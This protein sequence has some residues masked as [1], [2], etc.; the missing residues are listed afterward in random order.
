MGIFI[1][2]KKINRKTK[3]IVLLL[4]ALFISVITVNVIIDRIIRHNAPKDS[5]DDCGFIFEEPESNNYHFGKCIDC[6]IILISLDGFRPDHL[7][8][9]GYFRDTSPNIDKIAEKGVMFSNTYS[10]SYWTLPSDTTMF[11][12]LYPS[13][14]QRISDLMYKREPLPLTR[15][16]KDND[17]LTIGF[18]SA[19]FLGK[20]SFGAGFDSYM[21]DYEV[22]NE[23][24]RLVVP[25]SDKYRYIYDAIVSN[26]DRKFFMFIHSNDAWTQQAYSTEKFDKENKDSIVHNPFIWPDPEDRIAL[27]HYIAH[28]D[29]G[30]FLADKI[31]GDLN[32]LLKEQGIDNKTMLVL[33]SDHGHE[34]YEHGPKSFGHDAMSLDEE[35]IRVIFIIYNPNS[36][37][38]GIVID[39]PVG[40]IDLLP[41]ILEV[42]DINSTGFMQGSSTV[43]L[44]KGQDSFRSYVMTE[45]HDGLSGDVVKRS[46]VTGDWKFIVD[47]D[48]ES[49]E[50]YNLKKDPCAY[51]KITDKEGKI[52]ALLE[53]RIQKVADH[54][55]KLAEKAHSEELSDDKEYYFYDDVIH[56]FEIIDISHRPSYHELD[57]V[58][59]VEEYP[60]ITGESKKDKERDAKIKLRLSI[61]NNIDNDQFD[62]TVAYEKTMMNSIYDRTRIG[63]PG[64]ISK[65]R[66]CSEE[67]LPSFDR[68][69]TGDI[70]SE[71]MLFYVN[72]REIMG[73]CS[74]DTISSREI[75]SYVYSKK[76]KI[77]FI[78]ELFQNHD[79]TKQEPDEIDNNLK[80]MKS[81]VL[82]DI[83]GSAQGSFA[84][85]EPE[86]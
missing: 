28:Y 17:Y 10:Q 76:N 75:K 3:K 83:L 39:K 26:K 38:E 81:S 69:E 60:L 80:G 23:E 77:M 53:D 71:N 84:H 7:S 74:W 21:E 67:F 78:I 24:D 32:L 73:G 15:I 56:D 68:E 49:Y 5:Q 40:L 54:N 25:L 29:N 9:L 65:E 48:S 41:T 47:Y 44:I 79:R 12:S 37:K 27:K 57:G 6:N 59:V 63:Y 19:G 4:I 70:I 66:I 13:V 31:I 85:Q 42:V 61:M 86:E 50:L 64:I 82:S 2:K 33:T 72:Q 45:I 22:Q 1:T 43:P 36:N 51:K 8:A 18:G 55:E 20:W 30:I 46:I 52:K 35:S 34:F 58:T 11:S 16:L 14:H 62:E